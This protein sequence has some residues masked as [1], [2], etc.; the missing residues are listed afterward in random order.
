MEQTTLSLLAE[1]TC[2]EDRRAELTGEL[3]QMK[4][5]RARNAAW[6]QKMTAGGAASTSAGSLRDPWTRRRDDREQH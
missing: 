5:D 3:E 1:P 2:S 4:A 6:L